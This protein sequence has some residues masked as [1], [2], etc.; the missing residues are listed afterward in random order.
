MTIHL[1]LEKKERKSKKR[2]PTRDV[3]TKIEDAFKN[4]FL[5]CFSK[6][7]TEEC[8]QEN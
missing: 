4:K 7:K 2:K 5:G 8:D 1:D 3:E 6:A